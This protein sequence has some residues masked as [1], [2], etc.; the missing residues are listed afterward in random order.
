MNETVRSK[1][2][3]SVISYCP[4]PLYRA[5]MGGIG[6]PVQLTFIVLGSVRLSDFSHSRVKLSAT[7]VWALEALCRGLRW[8]LGP[9]PF[10]TRGQQ[11][12]EVAI[13]V[14]DVGLSQWKGQ[15]Q[16]SQA[17]SA[18]S[19]VQERRYFSGLP[20]VQPVFRDGFPIENTVP[21]GHSRRIQSARSIC[22]DQTLSRP[23]RRLLARNEVRV[24][25]GPPCVIRR[26]VDAGW[27]HP[28]GAN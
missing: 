24:A 23:I 5:P 22:W 16:A 15:P 18:S 20:P 19:G 25:S 14:D 3:H 4:A 8:P 26:I 11:A 13:P 7:S 28:H 10:K 12:S 9:R 6:P 2:T 27:A 21:R 1:R 17:V